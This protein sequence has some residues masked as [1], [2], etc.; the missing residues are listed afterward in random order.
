LHFKIFKI[1]VVLIIA[2]L[3]LFNRNN[4]WAP[5]GDYAGK[6]YLETIKTDGGS[7]GE[8]LPK[9][10]DNFPGLVKVGQG[11][12]YEETPIRKIAK[13]FSGIGIIGLWLF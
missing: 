8:F 4:F 3:V 2:L 1:F 11:Y 6:A 12:S 10:Y 13:I 5:I 9:N 7:W